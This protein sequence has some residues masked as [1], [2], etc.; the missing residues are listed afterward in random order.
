MQDAENGLANA[1]INLSNIIEEEK[2]IPGIIEGI[3]I[4]IDGYMVEYHK[5]DN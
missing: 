4:K 1:K 3:K 5:C 2:R